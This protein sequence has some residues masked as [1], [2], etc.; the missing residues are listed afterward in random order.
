MEKTQTGHTR[1]WG[2]SDNELGV[3]TGVTASL[4]LH[5]VTVQELAIWQTQRGGNILGA[6]AFAAE[7]PSFPATI[8]PQAWV[9]MPLLGSDAVFEVW[10]SA[11]P[12]VRDNGNGI[13]GARNADLLFACLSLDEGGDIETASRDAYCRIFDYLDSRSHGH[14]LRVWNYFPRI[15]AEVDKLERYRGFSIGRHDAFIAKGRAINKI[16]VPAACALGSQGGPMVIY[17][18]AAKEPGLPVE[19]PRQLSAYHYPE[20]YGPRSPIFS[21]ALLTEVRENHLLFISGTASIVGHESLHIGDAPAQARETVANVQAIIRQAAV[22]GLTS[23]GDQLDLYFKAYLRH[24]AHRPILENALFEA[25]GS[26]AKVIYLQADICRGDL[27][28]EVEGV[29]IGAPRQ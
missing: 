24:P 10:S 7:R 17:F 26:R 9:P 21:R 27:L 25:F 13:I 14:L 28:L 5:Y 20:Q 3:A 22:A 19:N 4:G 6:V 2:G 11:T 12:V 15:N 18:L 23:A 8:F 1:A 16:D 29:A